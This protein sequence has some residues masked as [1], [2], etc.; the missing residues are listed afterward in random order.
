MVIGGA[1]ATAILV[2]LGPG[3]PALAH[4]E[5]SVPLGDERLVPVV[6]EDEHVRSSPPSLDFGSVAVGGS[7]HR[8]L[9]VENV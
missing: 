6:F 9:T 7:V 1:A 2:A 3:W 8:Q 5:V 4:E